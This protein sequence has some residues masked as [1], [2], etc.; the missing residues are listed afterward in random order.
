M[1]V[2]PV[3]PWPGPVGPGAS[4]SVAPDVGPDSCIRHLPIVRPMQKRDIRQEVRIVPTRGSD[5]TRTFGQGARNDTDRVVGGF[6]EVEEE[7]RKRAAAV[8]HKSS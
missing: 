1:L 2:V 8:F 4:L 6:F 7:S 5:R 3:F